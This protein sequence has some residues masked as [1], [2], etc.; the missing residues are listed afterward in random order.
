[1]ALIVQKY[2][3]TSVGNTERIKNVAS[4]VAKYQQRGDR[5]LERR[6]LAEALEGAL[7]ELRPE[8]RRVVVLRYH[9]DLSHDEIAAV[10]GLPVG[11]VK[12]YLHRARAELAARMTARGWHDP[13]TRRAGGA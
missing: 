2:G 1:M 3:G 12:S 4:R 9:E 13:A 10:T 6:D 7:S 5:V 8:Y 11:T